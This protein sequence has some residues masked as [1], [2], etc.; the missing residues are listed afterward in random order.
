MQY[1]RQQMQGAALVLELPTDS[2]RPAQVS[3]RGSSESVMI[4]QATTAKLKQ[5]SREQG[6]TLFMSLLAVFDVLLG[7]YSGQADIVVGTSIAN[8]RRAERCF[9]ILRHGII[10]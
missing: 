6:A 2:A 5:L 9:R 7:S 4:S 3:Y 1:W 10:L 8:R